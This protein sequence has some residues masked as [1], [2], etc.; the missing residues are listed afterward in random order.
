[1]E[2][3]RRLT[4][5]TWPL[6]RLP[7]IRRRRCAPHLPKCKANRWAASKKQR[8]QKPHCEAATKACH[9]KL[10]VPCMYRCFTS[11]AAWDLPWCTANSSVYQRSRSLGSDKVRR[12]VWAKLCTDLMPVKH[13]FRP[14]NSS[15]SPPRIVLI[16][17]PTPSDVGSSSWIETPV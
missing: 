1:M 7:R 3:C 10:L 12:T 9:A 13:P 17:G 4:R 2:N 11:P 6:P 14:T 15:Q 16:P 8:Q 5:N